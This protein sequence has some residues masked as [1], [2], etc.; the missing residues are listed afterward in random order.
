MS[1]THTSVATTL[2][3]VT[4]E[5]YKMCIFITEQCTYYSFL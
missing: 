2:M 4:Q 1:N 3:I 5:K